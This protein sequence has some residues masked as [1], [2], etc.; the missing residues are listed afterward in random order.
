MGDASTISVCGTQCA[1]CYC[2][3]ELCQGCNACEGKVFHMP[4]GETCAIYECTVHTKK[5]KDCGA[6]EAAPCEIW[7]RTRDPK[8]SDEEFDRNIKERMQM[9]KKQASADA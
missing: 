9:L 7:L 6:C 3:G 2:Y 5:F 4:D 8:F 1:A